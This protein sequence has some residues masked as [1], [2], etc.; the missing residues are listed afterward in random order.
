MHESARP[1]RRRLAAVALV[2]VA[3]IGGIAPSGTA[4]ADDPLQPGDLHVASGGCTLNFVFDGTGANAGKVFFGTAAHCVGSVGQ[5][6]RDIDGHVFGRVAL[7]GNSAL[8]VRDW[9]FIEVLASDVERVRA[10]VKGHPGFPTGVTDMATASLGSLVQISGYGMVFGNT[11]PTQEQRI[12]VLSLSDAKQHRVIGPLIFG[13]SGGPLVHIDSGTAL[14]IVSRLCKT[15]CTETGPT[16]AN[17][18]VEAGAAGLDLTLRT[19]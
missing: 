12:A 13:D 2:A 15:G 4:V 7:V 14:G 9:A 16:V 11:Q 10:E 17:M 19:V 18:I 5:A 1:L 8:T 6:V 3:G